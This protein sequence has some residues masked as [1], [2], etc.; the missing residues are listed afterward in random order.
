MYRR[1]TDARRALT[2]AGLLVA[3]SATARLAIPGR[4]QPLVQAAVGTALAALVRARLGLA[5][6]A[7]RS[8]VRT[9]LTATAVAA[10][11][12]AASTAVPAVRTGM[13]ARA[14]PRP[15]WRW[16]ARDIPVGT[17][18]AEETAYRAALGTV[19]ASAFG[20]RRGRLLT[21]LA[22][23]L[24]HIVD[25]RGAGEPVVGTVVVTGLAGWVFG[26]LADWSGSLAAPLL[27]HLA[28]NEAGAVAALMVQ[29]RS[30][31][32]RAQM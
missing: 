20:P 25:A 3:Y 9:G 7:L 29:R 4:R 13:A 2:L 15:A 8:G 17:V 11:G 27:A 14:L 21:A 10:A 19:A 23:G 18:W 6:P 5:G 1:R 28:V 16:L 12:V 32:E 22:F 24:S 30:A 31:V 26:L